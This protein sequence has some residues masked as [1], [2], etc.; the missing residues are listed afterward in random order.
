M[1]VDQQLENIDPSVKDALFRRI[2]SD[3]ELGYLRDDDSIIGFEVDLKESKPLAGYTI[4]G[5][6]KHTILSYRSDLD[7]PNKLI[8]FPTMDKLSDMA[9]DLQ[10]LMVHRCI[11]NDDSFNGKEVS[12]GEMADV[13]HDLIPPYKSVEVSDDMAQSMIN[14]LRE[15]TLQAPAKPAP[16]HQKNKSTPEIL[17]T[18]D[19]SDKIHEDVP[20]DEF[21]EP[22]FEPPF[23][24]EIPMDAPM[25]VPSDDYNGSFDEPYDSPDEPEEPVE[26][27]NTTTESSKASE[28]KSQEFEQLSQ[29]SDY[30]VRY[31]NVSPDFASNVVNA[32]LNATSA[33]ETQIEVAVLLFVKLFNE[34]KL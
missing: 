3:D 4:V 12:H 32:A 16:A 33:R 24:D 19:V 27:V 23:D 29:V 9:F 7:E 1:N 14:T 21:D 25:D 28:L 34:N 2:M 15:S 10:S 5:V 22:P 13:A 30:V 20:F 31:M 11:Y 6:Q 18:P 17:D 26:V 8:L